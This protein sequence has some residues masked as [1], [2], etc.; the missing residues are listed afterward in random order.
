M[1]RIHIVTLCSYHSHK[2][3]PQALE[4]SKEAEGTTNLVKNRAFESTNLHTRSNTVAITPSSV[5]HF[6]YLERSGTLYI[7]ISNSIK[8][9]QYFPTSLA[10]TR[11]TR[12]SFLKI[13][14]PPKPSLVKNPLFS[15]HHRDHPPTSTLG[16]VALSPNCILLSPG[17]AAPGTSLSR[18][19]L[20]FGVLNPESFSVVGVPA[21]G[22]C[23][24]LN[25]T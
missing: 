25:S 24:G 5:H 18:S 7:F 6:T 22:V 13:L 19:A 3:E 12:K 23:P 4:Q 9:E 14:N 21:T 20:I 15:C 2:I 10:R 1:S 8:H 17:L 16:V 11:T